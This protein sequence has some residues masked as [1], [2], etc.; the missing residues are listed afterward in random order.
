MQGKEEVIGLL[1]NE[2]ELL[3]WGRIADMVMPKPSLASHLSSEHLHEMATLCR[4]LHRLLGLH[5]LLRKEKKA[6]LI[7]SL[8]R[9]ISREGLFSPLAWKRNHI[10]VESENRRVHEME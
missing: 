6:E 10:R 9:F 5:V 7:Q 3:F 2:A 1:E 4:D 8:R